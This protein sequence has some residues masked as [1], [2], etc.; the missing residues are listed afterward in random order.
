MRVATRESEREEGAKQWTSGYRGHCHFT[1]WHR[2]VGYDDDQQKS[3][4][5][6]FHFTGL[7]AITWAST[8]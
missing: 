8:A 5:D 1:G 4:S 7:F 6:A 3:H 2:Q